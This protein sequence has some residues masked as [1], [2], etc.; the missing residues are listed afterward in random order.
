VSQSLR[1]RTQTT[2]Q[3]NGELVQQ[4]IAFLSGETCIDDTRVVVTPASQACLKNWNES[5]ETTW[6]VQESAEVV[7]VILEF[8]SSHEGPNDEEQGGAYDRLAARGRL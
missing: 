5:V 7:V 4:H 2:V 1:S 6:V 8:Q 3:V